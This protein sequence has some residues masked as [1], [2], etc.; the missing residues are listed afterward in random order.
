MSKISNITLYSTSITPANI[1]CRDYYN[2]YESVG[3]GLYNV[4]GLLIENVHITQCEGPMP[5]TSTNDTNIID[6][7]YACSNLKH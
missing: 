4:S 3:F 7:I 2:S 6:Q 1:T 5:S